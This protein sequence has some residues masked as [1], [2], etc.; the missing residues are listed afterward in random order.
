VDT[1]SQFGALAKSLK[2]AGEKG[3]QREL[4]KA[5]RNAVAPLKAAVQESARTTLPRHGGLADRV[6]AAAVPRSRRQNSS[7]GVGL[8]VT[9]TGR[10][11]MKN[12][13]ALD[14]GKVR[15]PVYGRDAWVAQSVT[16]G[17]WS[18]PLEELAPKARAELEAAMQRIANQVGRSA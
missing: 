15:H 2:A 16:P 12:L 18:K 6:A 11:G 3:L 4:N 10:K 13:Q 5:V 8:R 17:F 9:A 14:A 1:A 7:K